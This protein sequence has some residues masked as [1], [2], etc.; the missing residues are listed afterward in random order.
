MPKPRLWEP[1]KVWRRQLAARL[2]R[3]RVTAR[4][5]SIIS[6]D[7]WG[8]MAYE[9]LVTRY[10]T[11]FVGLFLALEDYL[12]LLRRLKFYCESRLEFTD[13]SRHEEINVWREAIR[14]PYPIGLLG[15]DVEVQFLHYASRDEAETKWHRRAQRIH[16]NNLCVKMCW[17]DDARM[18]DWLREFDGFPF[19]RKLSLVPRHVPGLKHSVRLRDYSTDGTAQYWSSHRHFDVAAWLNEGVIRRATCG[20]ALDALLYWHY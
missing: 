7:C 19:E 1:V 3:R 2:M 9:E 6:N 11:P 14:K 5:F 10:D 4:N 8:G 16:W 20:R 17:H 12:R 18:E 15:G 13:R